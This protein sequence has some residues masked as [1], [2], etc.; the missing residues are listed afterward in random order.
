MFTTRQRR[1]GSGAGGN[2]LLL[3]VRA[4]L[5]LPLFSTHNDASLGAVAFAPSRAFVSRF[6]AMKQQSS[7]AVANSFI[8]TDLTSSAQDE[9]DSKVL[10]A[11]GKEVKI[12]AIARVCVEGLQAFQISSKGRGRFDDDKNF[13]PDTDGDTPLG[14]KYLAIPVGMRGTVN[15][16]Y[17]EHEVSANF[18]IRLKFESGKNTEEGYDTPQAFLMHFESSEVEIID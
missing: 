12:G 3:L 1:L 5:L 17:I 13:V 16:I 15:K 18:P 6:V 7:V 8:L 10:D 4:L 9:E 2:V 11:K 14:L